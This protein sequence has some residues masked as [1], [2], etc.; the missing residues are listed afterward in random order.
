MG[1][2]KFIKKAKIKP[3]DWY[4]II[5]ISLTVIFGSLNLYQKYDYNN[6]KS[7]YISLK[8]INEDLDNNIL[9]KNSVNKIFSNPNKKDKFTI[10]IIGE[11][12]LKG[13][14]VFKI[15]DSDGTELLNERYPSNDLIN[16]YIFDDKSTSNELE[17]Y[18]KKRVSE[19]FK[20]DNFFNSSSEQGCRV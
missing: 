3:I 5:A 20:E 13:E 7:Q 19:F 18:I 11:S 12:I 14:M 10:S 15:I 2:A 8:T 16:G 17:E 1:Y 9:L 6:L 4:K